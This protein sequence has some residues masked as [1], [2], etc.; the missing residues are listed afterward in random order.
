MSEEGDM[1]DNEQTQQGVRN[2][3]GDEYHKPEKGK[4]AQKKARFDN[5]PQ[6]KVCCI[7]IC[8]HAIV[9][10]LITFVSAGCFLFFIFPSF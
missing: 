4:P 7:V 3:Y 5:L 6:Q 1:T 2:P 10:N 8:I 9:L